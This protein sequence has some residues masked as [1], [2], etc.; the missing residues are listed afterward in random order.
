MKK[1]KND[2]RDNP[3]SRAVIITAAVIGI[4]F[5]LAAVLSVILLSAQPVLSSIV[6]LGCALNA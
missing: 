4:L 6:T 2:V 3:E 1:E 5:V